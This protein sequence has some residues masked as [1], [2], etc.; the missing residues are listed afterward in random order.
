[1]EISGSFTLW[2][3]ASYYGI[4]NGLMVLT[5][6]TYSQDANLSFLPNFIWLFVPLFLS[7]HPVLAQI[8][9]L[10]DDKDRL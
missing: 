7:C 10:R 5:M 8:L 1:M 4:S 2:S 6:A 3:L 9:E